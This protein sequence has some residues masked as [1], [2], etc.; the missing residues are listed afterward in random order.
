[1]AGSCTETGYKVT[2]SGA[3]HKAMGGVRYKSHYL[4]SKMHL[5]TVLHILS[6]FV[7]SLG[8]TVLSDDTFF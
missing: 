3:G 4:L 8:P 5:I 6:C 7:F 2:S 1:M